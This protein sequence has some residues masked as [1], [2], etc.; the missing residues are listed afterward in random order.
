MRSAYN[1]GNNVRCT[2]PTVYTVLTL[3]VVF[4]R[5]FYCEMFA[6]VNI[7]EFELKA[8]FDVVKFGIF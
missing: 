3:S 8:T 6:L 1:R 7:Y 2:D 5:Q 4:I